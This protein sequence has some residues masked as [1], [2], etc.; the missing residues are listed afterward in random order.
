MG[1]D[2]RAVRSHFPAL[3]AGIAHFDGP[4]GTQ[5]P[6]A[7]ADAVAAALVSPLANRGRVTAAERTRSCSVPGPRWR[8]CSVPTPRE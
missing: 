6:D 8:T 3:A 2:V 5:V 4:G 7:V 1:H